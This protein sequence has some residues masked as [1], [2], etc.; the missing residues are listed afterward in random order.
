MEQWVYKFD[1]ATPLQNFIDTYRD[2]IVGHVLKACYVE[3]GLYVY[4]DDASSSVF[5]I[6]DDLCIGIEYLYR[7]HV[8]IFT[9][10]ETDFEFTGDDPDEPAEKRIIFHSRLP[11]I[12]D[13]YVSWRTDMPAMNQIVTGIQIERHSERYEDYPNSWRPEGGD[14]F[15]SI[16]LTLEDGT[17]LYICGQDADSDGYTM[18]WLSNMPAFAYLKAEL[19]T[20]KKKWSYM[21]SKG[22][23]HIL[24]HS[25]PSRNELAELAMYYMRKCD[26][27]IENYRREK[28]TPSITGPFYT[29][30]LKKILEEFKIRGM[31]INYV[32]SS[33]KALIDLALEIGEE[34]SSR[35]LPSIYYKTDFSS[36]LK[37]ISW[38]IESEFNILMMNKKDAANIY[39]TLPKKVKDTSYGRKL[40]EFSKNDYED[41]KK[42][43][44]KLVKDLDAID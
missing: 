37:R 14:Y 18:V 29:Y 25:N 40:L 44:D 6:L 16:S 7:G 8:S 2:R 20:K 19:D 4:N 10:D 35:A 42:L 41:M 22:L 9:A 12:D 39:S 32:D 28:G 21:G 26:H 36:L 34:A 30:R 1:E 24:W 43:I 27:E 38:N 5:L 15:S 17:K 11:G 13:S 33:G 3:F 23:H 31:N